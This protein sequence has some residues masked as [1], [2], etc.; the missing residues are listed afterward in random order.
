[1]STSQLHN[2]KSND[3]TK[4]REHDCNSRR[5]YERL[6]STFLSTEIFLKHSTNTEQGDA[7]QLY[8]F[9]REV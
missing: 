6:F 4:K 5:G 7:M 8:T 2:V 1:M 9:F 3:N